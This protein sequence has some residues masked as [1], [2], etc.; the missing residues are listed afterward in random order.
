MYD[1]E[2][3]FNMAIKT[4]ERI[5]N[6]LIDCALYAVNNNIIAYKKNLYELYKESNPHLNKGEK[7]TACKK[8]A[9]LD[10][11][12]IKIKDE[13]VSFDPKL[14]ILLNA[15]DFWIRNKLHL[16]NLT[17]SRA[18]VSRGLDQQYKKYGMENKPNGSQE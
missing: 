13:R 15:F 2:I 9:L 8:W 14:M 3:P 4:L 16:H 18:E 6:L 1:T 5:H 10:A 12:E 17:F 7:E 11:Y